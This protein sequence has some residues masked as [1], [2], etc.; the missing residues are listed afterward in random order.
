MQQNQS[1]ST[2][3]STERKLSSL[4]PKAFGEQGELRKDSTSS[5]V[6]SLSGGSINRNQDNLK[7]AVSDL[8]HLFGRTEA[9]RLLQ[10]SFVDVLRGDDGKRQSVLVHGKAGTGKTA[11]V[12]QFY[13][14]VAS[15]STG[16]F[17]SGIFRRSNS[18][19]FGAIAQALEG[20]CTDISKEDDIEER[21][22]VL[23]SKFSEEQLN[24][25]LQLL[26][27]L[28]LIITRSSEL[29]EKPEGKTQSS[30]ELSSL[31][32]I[33]SADHVASLFNA[34]LRAL[35]QNSK[36][37]VIFLDNLQWANDETSSKFIS[38]ILS[39]SGSKNLM[40]IGAYRD[41]DP[42]EY[43][44]IKNVE[45]KQF[46]DIE[47]GNLTLENVRDLLSDLTGRTKVLALARMIKAKTHGNPSAVIE[48]LETLEQEELLEYSFRTNKWSWDLELIRT[49]TD[50]TAN[51]YE[52]L[53]GRI[54]NLSNTHRKVLNLAAIIGFGFDPKFLA[55]LS[56]QLNLLE[57][58]FKETTRDEESVVTSQT[59]PGEQISNTS[60]MTKEG[61][62]SSRRLF[63]KSTVQEALQQAEAEGLISRT[64]GNSRY[65]FAHSLVHQS[66]YH[67]SFVGQENR[68]KLHLR[69]A[70]AMIT[71]SSIT[72]KNDKMFLIAIDHYNR[73]S[74]Y[75]ENDLERIN[76][77]KLNRKAAEIAKMNRLWKV[78]TDYL[79]T[80][81]ELLTLP[82]DWGDHYDLLVEL[83]TM[84][85]ELGSRCQKSQ[86]SLLCCQEVQK[87][88]RCMGDRLRVYYVR[89]KILWAHQKYEEA[90]QS[91]ISVLDQLGERIGKTPKKSLVQLE[92][93]RTKKLLSGMTISALLN[94]PVMTDQEQHERMLFLG[95]LAALSFRSSEELFSFVVLKML[96]KSITSGYCKFTPFA[97]AGYAAVA[98]EKTPEAFEYGRLAIS[99]CEME[100]KDACIPSA[101]LMVYTFLDHLR[102]P[103]ENSSDL[104]L[105]GYQIATEN[106]QLELS[107][108]C[109]ASFAVIGFY[110]SP[111][112]DAYI[113]NLK[114]SRDTL[115]RH[116]S[117]V[118]CLIA[119]Y[120][121]AAENLTGGIT[122]EQNM[123]IDRTFDERNILK[124]FPE[125]NKRLVCQQSFAV[126]YVVA[127]I[128]NDVDLAYEAR[129]EMRA[130]RTGFATGLHCLVYIELFFS[131]LLNFARQ[132]KCGG[133]RLLRQAKQIIK[134]ME[135]H[136]K[137]ENVN[138][139][140][141]LLLLKA[142][143]AAL[144]GHDSMAHNLYVDAIESFSSVS[145]LQFQAIATERA[146]EFL[147]R[148]GNQAAFG[149]YIKKAASLYA[150]WG[151]L[152]KVQQLVEEY[153]LS[154]DFSAADA[155]P[156][157]TI[158]LLPDKNTDVN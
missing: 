39:Q 28:K 94:L 69:I 131:G 51:V 41:D 149:E 24:Q 56:W 66:L 55:P 71:L 133:W 73:G 87:N 85:A 103:L 127:Y 52:V 33:E 54:E 20:L 77:I 132:R 78:A 35:C 19:P 9:Q 50:V 23:R 63:Y 99:L 148:M 49:K 7:V 145:L 31:V 156:V 34:L 3:S 21:R 97:L 123:S 8:N 57:N 120:L 46:V 128:F 142:E 105:K 144:I 111:R 100:N 30:Q 96:Q 36:P 11:L 107:V 108:N 98:I 83:Y 45:R 64:I 150:D 84:S 158:P 6:S 60:A 114:A 79:K 117:L 68:D 70:R 116:S 74:L 58:E 140:A 81:I 135:A 118:R 147:L 1:A 80:A 2:V 65:K 152:A 37:I 130:R 18:P 143:L 14:A 72:E 101:Y 109:M 5:G 12:M 32:A 129:N 25:L 43:A 126:A 27:Y 59:V 86:F 47:V 139:H 104:L 88:S 67:L 16:Y 95:L 92:L 75:I 89:I 17:S 113:H 112:L 106:G 26:P 153:E 13:D 61:S 102:H 29:E 137:E 136:V 121:Q 42:E 141:M 76:L 44:W 40:F 157:I 90:V 110:S 48:F 10:A 62:N 53:E 155:P 138:C 119:P 93:R 91:S 124:S 4:S 134:Q 122:E 146:A 22:K 125:K 115:A 82:T 154:P 38:S 151:A 15:T